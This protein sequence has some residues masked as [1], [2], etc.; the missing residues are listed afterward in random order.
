M[1][2]KFIFL[3]AGVLATLSMVG[4]TVFFS[5]SVD[6]DQGGSPNDN[7]EE[8]PASENADERGERFHDRTSEGDEG[9][10]DENDNNDHRQFGQ[11]TAHDNGLD[12]N[13]M[14]EPN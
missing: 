12:D 10:G 1:N 7:A 8:G 2:P 3:L 11:I 5:Q 9:D 14:V 13:G 6:A 4:T